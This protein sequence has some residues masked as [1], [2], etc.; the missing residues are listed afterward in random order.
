MTHRA[1]GTFDVVM[2]PQPTAASAADAQPNG[3]GRMSLDK[4]FHGDLVATGSGEM[5]TAMTDTKGSA[6]YVA[7]EMVT[8]TLQGMTGSFMLQHTGS[9]NRGA[10]SLTITVVPDSGRGELV[11]ISGQLTIRI[12]AGKHF[13]D[14]DY[15]LP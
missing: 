11:G 2:Q 4:T 10:P 3:V 13:Y 14:F 6:G 1:T 8:G 12:D 9:M 5:L 7:V 15:A